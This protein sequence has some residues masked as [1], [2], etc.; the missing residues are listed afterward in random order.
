MRLEPETL[1]R[2]P[3]EGA[4]VVAFREGQL[5]ASAPTE[6]DGACTFAVARAGR[7]RLEVRRGG[8]IEGAVELHL[9]D[10][11]AGG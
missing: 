4:R 8:V 11:T 9:L 6:P 5:L 10:E 2:T 7:Y 3:G 1:D